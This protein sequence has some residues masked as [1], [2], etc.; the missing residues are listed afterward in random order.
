[1]AGGENLSINDR[2][3]PVSQ[4]IAPGE[5]T[6]HRKFHLCASHPKAILPC[7]AA[8]AEF[9]PDPALDPLWIGYREP[10]KGARKK[11]FCLQ[12][13][14]KVITG[15]AREDVPDGTSKGENTNTRTKP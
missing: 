13:T 12:V 6:L 11:E 2:D 5:Y 7:K 4:V 1:V 15:D 3:G 10:F 9:A 8:S 14:L